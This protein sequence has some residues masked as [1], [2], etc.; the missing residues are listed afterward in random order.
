[1]ERLRLAVLGLGSISLFVFS[2]VVLSALHVL[3]PATFDI[4]FWDILSSGATALGAIATALAA[5]TALSVYKHQRLREERHDEELDSKY[6]MEQCQEAAEKAMKLLVDRNGN[7]ESIISAGLLLGE[8]TQLE[9][10]I[11][12]PKHQRVYSIHREALISRYEETL[13]SISPIELTG[14]ST[15]S[16]SGAPIPLPL[17]R[18][19]IGKAV[20]LDRYFEESLLDGQ[21]FHTPFQGVPLGRLLCLLRFCVNDAHFNPPD[22]RITARELGEL[23]H[24]REIRH[25]RDYI[26]SCLNLDFHQGQMVLRNDP[27]DIRSINMNYDLNIVRV[28]FDRV[29]Q[30]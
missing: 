5:F 21:V 18:S 23:K 2:A 30:L 4:G 9:Q 22:E 19:L 7:S 28:H 17:D 27:V 8:V 12:N 1:M 13:V 16:E 20:K 24:L 10:F 6:Y 29:H 3:F 11:T 14:V 26:F 25:I 15:K